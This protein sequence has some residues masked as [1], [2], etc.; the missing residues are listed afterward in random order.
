MYYVTISTFS[1]HL[2]PESFSRVRG[3][4]VRLCR[5]RAGRAGGRCLAARPLRVCVRRRSRDQ[6][7][8]GQRPA[9]AGP[10]VKY[11]LQLRA[12]VSRGG[13]PGP[14]R[15]GPVTPAH[16]KSMGEKSSTLNTYQIASNRSE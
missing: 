3:G 14:L 5:C 12:G 11:R 10:T 13:P 16:Y 9:G 8:W 2:L 4:N 1:V 6:L 15:G 7:T